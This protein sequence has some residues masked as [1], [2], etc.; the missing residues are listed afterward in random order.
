MEFWGDE[1]T[2]LFHVYNCLHF[3][4][5]ILHGKVH[6]GVQLIHNHHYKKAKRCKQF[7]NVFL[8]SMFRMPTGKIMY[9]HSYEKLIVFLIHHQLQKA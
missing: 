3:F 6:T 2:S 4:E 8:Q 7:R 1:I 9:F 5:D